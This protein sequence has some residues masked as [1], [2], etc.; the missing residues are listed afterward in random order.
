MIYLPQVKR[1]CKEYWKIQNY[2]QAINS[3]EIYECH[4]ILELTINGEFAHTVKE[5]KR[6][7]MY[8]HR[9]YFEL[10]FL[11]ANDHAKLHANARSE[12]ANKLNSE[13][14]KGRK[15][16]EEHKRKI[17]IGSKGHIVTEDQKRRTALAR[18]GTKLKLGNDGKYH[19]SR[20]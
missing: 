12:H 4:H 19:W 11:Q 18:K 15:L 6:L 2:E 10:I 9:P 13:Y 7:N 16:S 5:L 8:Y 20:I 14:H 1:Y 3:E 17:G